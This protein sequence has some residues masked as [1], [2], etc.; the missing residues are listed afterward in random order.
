MELHTI[1]TFTRTHSGIIYINHQKLNRDIYY[2]SQ[3]VKIWP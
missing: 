1:K 2:N 3:N